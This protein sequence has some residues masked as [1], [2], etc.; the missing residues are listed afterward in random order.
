MDWHARLQ[1]VLD[2]LERVPYPKWLSVATAVASIVLLIA[3][4]SSSLGNLRL[5][6]RL[7]ERDERADD[8]APALLAGGWEDDLP[9]MSLEGEGRALVDRILPRR[10]RT[11]VLAIAAL[12]IGCWLLGLALTTDPHG[13]LTSLEWQL[14]P[15]YLAAHFITLRLFAT[16]FTRNFR[17]GVVHLEMPAENARRGIRLVLGPVGALVALGLAAPFCFYDYQ[18][19]SDGLGSAA[20]RLLLAM[21]SLE[22]FLLAFIW[23]QMLGFVLLTRWALSEHRFRAPIE[24]VL[25]ERQYRPFLQMSV[26]GATIV[27]GFFI[28]NAIYVWFTLGELSDY[29]GVAITLLLLVVGFVPPWIQLTGKVDRAVAQEMSGLRRRLADGAA[30]VTAAPQQPQTARDLEERLDEALVMLRISYLERLHGDLGQVEA[31]SVLMKV[32]VPATTMG[33]YVA[34]AM[35]L[36]P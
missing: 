18:L 9:A 36:A 25:H 14:Q 24:M 23:V 19:K 13:F 6:Q 26:Q 1:S 29:V 10:P 33:Y 7:A 32:L 34:K 16:M 31:K 11:F 3:F 12:S 20:D 28:V 2:H 30:R 35:K 27:L 5:R 21:W 17:A 15:I 4:I 8:D 22:W